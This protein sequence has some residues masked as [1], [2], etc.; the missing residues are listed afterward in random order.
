MKKLFG[1]IGQLAMLLLFV[2][3]PML[4]AEADAWPTDGFPPFTAGQ[5]L[6]CYSWDIF[7]DERWKFALPTHSDISEPAEELN[8]GHPHQHALPVLG[9]HINGCYPGSVRPVVGTLITISPEGQPLGARLGMEGFETTGFPNICRDVEIQCKAGSSPG[10]PPPVWDC[11]SMNKFDVEHPQSQLI[12]VVES[13]DPLCSLFENG[14]VRDDFG[15]T[16]LGIG[17]AS[18]RRTP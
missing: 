9:N 16:T 2:G 11:F 4:P 3:I 6:A 5:L 10:F 1:P 7:P 8:F 13:E 14:E 18:G 17:P 12:Q 15:F